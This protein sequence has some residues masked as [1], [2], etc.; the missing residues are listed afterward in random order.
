[1]PKIQEAPPPPQPPTFL[2]NPRPCWAVPQ[3]AAIR[4]LLSE[5]ETATALGISPAQVRVLRAA[6][7]LPTVKIG[8]SRLYPLSGLAEYI[9]RLERET[10]GAQW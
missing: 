9:T 4:L 10:E 5:P 7:E 8:A 6:G 2:P 1:M 3:N